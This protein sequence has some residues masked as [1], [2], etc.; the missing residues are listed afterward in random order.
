VEQAAQNI[1]DMTKSAERF[2]LE[3]RDSVLTPMEKFSQTIFDI[4]AQ[5][6]QMAGLA[7]GDIKTG[8]LAILNRQKGKTIA[9][10]IGAN[11]IGSSYLAERA[12]RGSREEFDTVMRS[13]FGDQGQNI[14][15]R[16]YHR[17]RAIHDFR[18]ASGAKY[19]GATGCLQSGAKTRRRWLHAQGKITMGY[20]QLKELNERT[21]EVNSHY[22]R[23]YTRTFLVETD[24]PAYGPFY[25]ASHPSLPVIYSR[26]MKTRLHLSHQ[27]PRH[28]RSPTVWKISCRYALHSGWVRSFRA[29]RISGNRH[30]ATG[31]T[32]C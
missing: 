30:P 13:R 2:N 15:Q 18:G 4:E 14:Q 24:S 23:T 10:F 20:V 7:N 22:Q 8:N 6:K 16:I 17:H 27:S 32:S 5:Q 19:Q 11:S 3:M 31:P 28:P 12:S 1:D 9:D 25:A 26:T 21:G 29:H